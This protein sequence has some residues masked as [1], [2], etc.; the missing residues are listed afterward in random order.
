MGEGKSVAD[1]I[2]DRFLKDVEEKETMPW[3]RPYERYNAFNY[4]TMKPYRGINRLMLP[5]G[6]YMTANQV[7]QYNKEHNED[8]KFQKGITWY[9]IV[10]FKK[11][12]KELS[13][14]RCMKECNGELPEEE[15]YIVNGAWV[16]RCLEGKYLKTRNV[17]RYYM[18]ADRAHFKNSKGELLPSRVETGEVIIEKSSAKDI[19]DDYIAREGIEVV[20]TLDCPSYSP[21]TDTI[22]VNKHQRSL[23]E[24]FSCN[25]HEAAH[26][27]GHKSRLNRESI[28]SLDDNS[29]AVEE[30]I[31][32]I[33]ACLLCA[34]CGI[35]DFSTSNSQSYKNNIAYVQ[36][37]KKKVRDFGK[38]FIYIVSRSDS[39]FSFVM[40]Q[41]I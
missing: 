39:A 18:V 36:H 20:E 29:R 31:A 7:N 40:G 13:M 24:Y 30:C 8:F 5:F 35:H 33:T 2:I 19:F 10:F 17:L 21:L 1:I 28:Y 37:W 4:F 27:T 22:A 12:V 26:S 41:E 14:E 16:Y 32:E 34:E 6:E 11:E 38:E 9:P 3:Q 23:D 15:G 25:F